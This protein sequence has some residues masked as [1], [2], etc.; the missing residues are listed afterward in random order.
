MKKLPVAYWTVLGNT[1]RDTD[2][3][4]IT[5]LVKTEIML[6]LSGKDLGKL[7]AKV[8]ADGHRIHTPG[9]RQV[10]VVDSN[11]H[12]GSTM[13]DDNADVER[14]HNACNA[15]MRSNCSK[16]VWKQLLQSARS[17]Q[18]GWNLA[19]FRSLVQCS[20]LVFLVTVGS[21]EAQ[22]GLHEGAL[23]NCGAAKN[24]KQ[25]SGQMRKSVC[26]STCQ[27]SCATFRRTSC[28]TWLSSRKDEPTLLAQ[29]F[30]SEL[31]APQGHPRQTG[32]FAALDRSTPHVS[33]AWQS[34]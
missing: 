13:V 22:W 21:S 4:S 28:A 2:F 23:K 24:T 26:A 12:L 18:H 20:C 15:V 32:S 14:R 11:V 17:S 16:C 29:P 19:L 31:P 25:V 7:K 3:V 6:Q 30:E 1:V 34:D 8:A 5:N 9:G 27:R 33:V 10:R